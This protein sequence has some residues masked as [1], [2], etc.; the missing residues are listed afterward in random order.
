MHAVATISA[1]MALSSDMPDALMAVS[2]LLSPRLPMVMSEASS[3]ASG[4][5]VGTSISAIYQKNC[6]STSSDRPLPI[7][8]AT[9]FHRNCIISTNRL[10]KNVPANSAR[11]C[12]SMNM[13]SFFIKLSN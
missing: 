4:S 3:T 7:R 11:N 10:M 9:Y 8:S 12:R 2:S 13:S 1:L 5:A 6:A